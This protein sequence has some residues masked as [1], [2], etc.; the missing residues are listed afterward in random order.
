M[1]FSPELHFRALSFAAIAHGEQK[2]AFG[3]PYV[4]HV[5]SV[6]MEVMA[7]LRTEPGRDEDLA[8]ACAL[9]YP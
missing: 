5:T 3:L 2:T 7:A 6:A 1:P 4:V 9:L 8:V